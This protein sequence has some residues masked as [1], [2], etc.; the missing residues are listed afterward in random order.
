MPQHIVAVCAV[1]VLG[2][3]DNRLYHMQLT[4]AISMMLEQ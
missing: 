4:I 3:V 1:L 2:S